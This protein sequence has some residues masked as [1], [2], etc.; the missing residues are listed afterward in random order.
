MGSLISK[1]KAPPAPAPLIIT[2]PAPASAP[3]SDSRIEDVGETAADKAAPK[4]DDGEKN[5]PKQSRTS[6]LLRR[7]RGT[8]GTILTSF[9]GV[10]NERLKNEP[11]KT[12][13]GE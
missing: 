1:P 9:R 7:S 2:N 10:L 13:L 3:E 8:G 4:S 5:T 12:L 11:R 6:D